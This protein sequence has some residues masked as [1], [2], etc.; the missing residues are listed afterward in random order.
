MLLQLQLIL[1]VDTRWYSNIQVSVYSSSLPSG[2]PSLSWPSFWQLKLSNSETVHEGLYSSQFSLCSS[3]SGSLS[4]RLTHHFQLLKY[5][6]QQTKQG[7]RKRNTLQGSTFQ[8]SLLQ[9]TCFMLTLQQKIF[10]SLRS[11][12][13]FTHLCRSYTVLTECLCNA[14]SFQF[15]HFIYVISLLR[16]LCDGFQK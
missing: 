12:P 13:Y 16:P 2:L 7:N 10:C 9:Q 4:T 8:T 1:K 15:Q 11:V 3:R 5:Q 6:S 14:N